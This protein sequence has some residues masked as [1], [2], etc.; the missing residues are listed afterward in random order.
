MPSQGLSM[1]GEYETFNGSVTLQVKISSSVT[2]R[3]SV[4]SKES[5]NVSFLFYKT[6]VRHIFAIASCAYAGMFAIG[7]TFC[8]IEHLKDLLSTKER[9]SRRNLVTRQCKFRICH[10]ARSCVTSRNKKNLG[11]SEVLAAM[12][13]QI[14]ATTVTPS[15]CWLMQN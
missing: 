3:N 8:S 4:I 5:R 11:Y 7:P 13:R 10:F 12:T 14:R 6:Y 15:P 1:I 9:V 2:Q